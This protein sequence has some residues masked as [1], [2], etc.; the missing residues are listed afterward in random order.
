M[1]ESFHDHIW[2]GCMSEDFLHIPYYTSHFLSSEIIVP[3]IRQLKLSQGVGVEK[4]LR[5]SHDISS[6]RKNIFH[7]WHVA[8]ECRICWRG[9]ALY[10]VI[11]LQC[12]KRKNC[13][14]NAV[15]ERRNITILLHPR[16]IGKCAMSYHVVS[17]VSACIKHMRLISVL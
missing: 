17:E 8:C 1:R 10:S 2:G 9:T 14:D 12:F 5:H 13:T 6:T 11:P 3:V 16:V 15:A 7:I 4:T